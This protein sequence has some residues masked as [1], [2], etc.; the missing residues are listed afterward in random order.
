[1]TFKRLVFL[2]LIISLNASFLYADSEREKQI[3]KEKRAIYE[4]VSK[5]PNIKRMADELRRDPGNK[6]KMDTLLMQLP[7]SPLDMFEIRMESQFREY[8][9][10]KEVVAL[11][12]RWIE[13]H[14]EAAMS[15]EMGEAL[16]AAAAVFAPQYQIIPLATVGMNRD[17]PSADYDGEIQ[18]AVNK[19]NT[20]QMVASANSWGCEILSVFNSTDGGGTW[21]SSCAPS[22]GTFGL[23]CPAGNVPLGSDPAVYWDNLG[24]VFLN[25]MLLCCDAACQAG[26]GN[27]TSSLVV[28]KSTNAGASWTGHG[29]IVNNLGNPGAGFDDKQFYIVDNTPTSSFY[30]RH[31]QCWDVNNNGKIAWSNTGGSTWNI[32]DTPKGATGDLELGC[33]MAVGKNGTVHMVFDG[34]TCGATCSAEKTYYTRSINGGVSW[35][36][37]VLVKNHTVVSFHTNAKIPPQNN[38]GVNPFGAIDID[39]SGGSFDGTLYF[40]YSASS[41]TSTMPTSDIYVTRSTDNGATW[42]AGVKVNDDGTSTAQFHPFLVVD[43]TNGAVVVGWHDARNDTTNNRKVDYYMSRSVDQGVTWEANT[44]VSQPSTAFPGN[45]TIS[46]SDENSSDNSGRNPN[47]YGEYLGVD[48]HAGKAWMAWTDSR[49]YYPNAGANASQKEDVAFATIDFGSCTLPTV[50]SLVSPANGA[51]SVSTTPALDW[52]DVSGATSYDVQVCSDSTCATVVRSANV[53]SST[54][55]VSPSL[56][57]STTYYWRAR[58]NNSCG[59]GSFSS[60]FSFTTVSG[61]GCTPASAAFDATLQAPRCSATACG[62]DTGASIINGRGTMSG[63]IESNAPNTINDSCLDGNSGTYHSDESLDRLSISTNDGTALAGGKTVTI[64]ATAWCWGTADSLDLFYTS[65]AASPSWTL[66]GTE[67]CT[68]GGVARTFTASYTLPSTGTL[69]AIRAQFRYQSTNASCSSGNYNDRDDLIF[70]VNQAADTT[71]P[72]TSITA[73]VNG[74]TVSGTVTVSANASDNVGVTKVEFYLDGTTLLATDTT[75]PYSIS[76]NTTTTSNGAHNLTGKAF[77]AAN[78]STTSTPVNVTVNNTPAGDLIATFNPTYQAPACPSGGK[79]CDTGATLIQGRGTMTN[80]VESNAPNT[81]NDSCLDGNSGTFHVDESIDQMKV[82]TNDGTALASG[83]TVTVTV[84]VWCYDSTDR[85]DLYRTSNAATPSWTL[86]NTQ[87]CTASGV[88]KT[89]TATYTLPAGANQAVRGNYRFGGTASTCTSGSY[90]DRD[91]LVFGV[92]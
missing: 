26:T 61:G 54:W 40:S 30:G 51:T 28:A 52:S 23:S 35:S 86:I 36:T 72:T 24:A 69:Q 42:S 65:N 5:D 87:A 34:L 16:V 57:N 11:H 37:P 74:A 85:L 19:N 27:P 13:L 84:T 68:A 59:A 10:P 62:C 75:S 33:E 25:Y 78:N 48:A 44:K 47:Q 80:G 2:F 9:V 67:A 77:D 29:V 31:Y 20:N 32:V 58:A 71:P 64:S 81:I 17:L 50:P 4:V 82:A 12:R 76:W 46:Y 38:R 8:V 6:S 73:P 70:A 66:I 22:V 90:N 43:Q 18:L 49:S 88:A 41:S 79:S 15:E 45:T 55:T 91:D 60:T 53:A 7:L 63:G 21:N 39:N 1:M 14:P 3:E 83:K 89:F 56:S 92:Q